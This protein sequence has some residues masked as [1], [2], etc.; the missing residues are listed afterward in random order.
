MSRFYSTYVAPY[1]PSR[2]PAGLI[3]EGLAEEVVSRLDEA[4]AAFDNARLTL[5]ARRSRA[6]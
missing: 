6:A 2:P 4:H 1:Q 5:T 3:P